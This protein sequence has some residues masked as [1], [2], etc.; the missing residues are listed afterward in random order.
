MDKDIREMLERII[1]TQGDLSDK[2]DDMD[3]KEAARAER[4]KQ[5]YDSVQ[6]HEE[7]INGNGKI[8]L[9]TEVQLLKDHVRRINWVM[10]LFT[11]AFIVDIASRIFE[12]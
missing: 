10:G 11:A 8:G 7:V 2:L 3:R 9:K 5:F 12:K 6:R 4:E 1:K